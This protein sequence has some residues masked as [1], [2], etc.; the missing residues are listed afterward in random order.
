MIR[1]VIVN[2][3]H[4]LL[5]PVT[6]LVLVA[7]AAQT[8]E[9]TDGGTV[10][11]EP[12]ASALPAS[13]GRAKAIAA[14]RDYLA[15]YPED[16]EYDRITRRLADLLVEQAAERQLAVA[17]TADASAKL[18]ADARQ[19]YDEAIRR[20]EYLLQKYPDAPDSTEVL[21]QLSRAYEESGRSQQAVAVIGRLLEKPPDNSLRLYA[22]TQFRRGELLFSAGDYPAA[23]QS[24][25][26]VVDLGE[27]LPAYEQALYKLGWSL[28]KQERYPEALPVLFRFLDRK[29]PSG[30][31]PAAQPADRE[32]I[33]DGL[34]VISM[35]FSQLGGVAAVDA[36][37]RRHDAY[38]YADRIYLDLAQWYVEQ[39][40]ITEAAATWQA[41][42][43]RDPLGA[44]APR[45]LMRAIQLYREAG[46]ESPGVELETA[47]GQ[48]YGLGRDF[49][50]VHALQDFPD[51]VQALQAS[52]RNVARFHHRQA[53]KNGDADEVRAAEQAYRE[54]LVAF[55]DAPAAADMN[56]QLAE[57][58]Y[59]SAH[60]RQAIEEYE[61]TAWSRGD[62]A[63]AAEA[64]L[65]MLRASERVLQQ[66][67]VS[68]RAAVAERATTTAQ[69]FIIAFPHHPAAAGI[70]AQTGTGWLEQ[71]QYAAA[72][73]FSE[74][75][76]AEVLDAP[77]ALR[78]AAWSLQAQAQYGLMHYPAA[79]AAYREAL[80]LAGEADPRRAALQKGLAI[81][82]Y[83][84]AEQA[85]ARG[86]QGAAL[87]LYQ[88]AA[89][90]APDTALR[91]R[92]QFNAATA[93]LAQGAWQES[94]RMLLQFRS[95]YPG[96]A[97]Q[98]E[99]TRKLAYAYDRSGQLQQAAAEYLHLGRDRR[100]A[101]ALQREALLQAADLYAQ[102]GA[103]P[104]AIEARKQYLQRF[105]QPV[106][107][108][109]AVM[110]AL[111]DLESGLGHA[112][113]RQHW[114]EEIVRQDAAAGTA[115]TRGPA[116]AAALELAQQKLADFRRVELNHPVQEQLA[117]KLQ[118]MRHALEGF[119]SAIAY[120]IGP[121][122]TAA[123]Y[124]IASMYDELA[125]AL[126][127]SAR[128]PGLNAA[129]LAEYNLLLAEQVASFAQQAIELYTTNARRSGEEPHDPWVEK[130][131]QRLVE[132]RG[133]P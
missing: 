71:Q 55:A 85:V 56:F 46:F 116:A 86:D 100:Q 133:S 89:Q 121:V 72:L 118:L 65:G 119:E 11:T 44:E 132:L 117:R 113:Q 67:D 25:Q 79:A 93:L 29:I 51:V 104:R 124:Q 111:A 61:R 45:L 57:L 14:Y 128:P 64:A 73:R 110:Q 96:D 18:Q 99:V 4:K 130:S 80:Q 30:S 26:A 90:R 24:Y 50:M 6:C 123:T 95:D 35:S 28:F 62:H 23:E 43:Q 103:V 112:G 105:P 69:R 27:A 33:A 77:A 12:A 74:Q 31:A 34:R 19:A 75:V 36:F 47:F 5:V 38:S 37:F 17:T 81:A 122:S 82:T 21:Y 84:Q 91:A 107:A 54:Y 2:A 49:W 109:V 32:Q 1:P 131:L 39:E 53:R 20:Y 114:L 102:T 108:A 120:G 52:L 41:L 94:I 106:P 98:A 66:A 13:E 68:D 115:Q 127:T 126:Q 8:L 76:L 40:R 7:C 78:Q 87:A 92:A 9:P 63:R 97:L 125:R 129:E 42:A 10:A 70:L 59:E 16:P 88:Q 60:Y 48:R 58:L 3:R 101:E 15:R 22:D 83:Q